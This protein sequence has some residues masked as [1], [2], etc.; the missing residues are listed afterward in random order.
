MEPDTSPVWS[1]TGMEPGILP[2]KLELGMV[3]GTPQFASHK[4]LGPQPG[5]WHWDSGRDRRRSPSHSTGGVTCNT[6]SAAG[7]TWF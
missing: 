3:R 6:E 4:V 5:S 1:G 7:H 2:E